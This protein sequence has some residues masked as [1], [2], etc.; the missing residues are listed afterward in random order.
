MKE[1]QNSNHKR[2][3]TTGTKKNSR[4]SDT[5]VNAENAGKNGHWNIK[6]R[7]KFLYREIVE[8]KCQ[9]TSKRFDAPKKRPETDKM[10]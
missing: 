1:S 5:N 9:K 2:T 8:K 3:D 7:R 10:E 4:V 6:A